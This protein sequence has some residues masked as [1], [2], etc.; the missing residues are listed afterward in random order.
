MS[1]YC[2]VVF[3]LLINSCQSRAQVPEE[4]P[5]PPLTEADTVS[6][7]KLLFIGDVMGHGPQIKSAYVDS[8]KTYNYEP[9]FKYVKPIVEAAD[10]AVG[11]LEVTLAKKGPYAGY[12]RFRSPDALAT[13]LRL[14]GFDMMVTANNHSNDGGL[15]GVLHT[16][17]T[18]KG[19]G[20]YQTGT[21][22]NEK[23]REGFYPLIVFK[24]DFKLAFLN[25][26]Y[27]TNGL[28]TKAPAIV[29]MIDTIQMETDMTLAR[30]LKP[31]A[32]IVLMH[33]GLEYKL[34][35]SEEQRM[36]TQKLYDWGADMVIGAHPHV[37]QPIKRK[38]IQLD[39]LTSKEV[40]VTYSLGNFISNQSKPNT[41]GGIIYEIELKKHKTNGDTWL[42]EDAYIPVWRY[43]H[44]ESG[45]KA[46]YHAVP[47]SAFE[48][49]A[50]VAL[51][52]PEADVTKMK[53][54]AKKTREHLANYGAKERKIEITDII[55]DF[56][57]ELEAEGG[58]SN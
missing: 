34:I 29:N 16:I 24:N 45:K 39:S 55:P 11:N 13:A 49:H 23:E 2:L 4:P 57:F 25:Y 6:T 7:I 35:E 47:V 30:Q 36:L 9:V 37:V 12:P 48:E 22:K 58:E 26:T 52:M 31:D 19:L 17:D 18:L 8:T 21:F 42:G 15:S 44:K 10:L 54:F 33:W 27:G 1:W 5:P 41:D 32:I 56:V 20:F 43:I 46:V 50:G 28:A 38:T 53:A 3:V 14:A 40:V 51:G